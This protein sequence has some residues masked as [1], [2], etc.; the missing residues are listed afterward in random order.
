MSILNHLGGLALKG[1]AEGAAHLTGV[2]AIAASTEVI[3]GL[4]Q[5]Q[6]SDNSQRLPRAIERAATRAWRAVEVSLAGRS[7]WDRCKLA[8][9]TGDDRAIRKQVGA[10]LDANPLDGVDGHGPDFRAQCLAQLRAA[11]KAGLLDRG[12]IDPD[13]V[14]R[15]VGDLSRFGDKSATIDAEYGVLV[16]I[17][18]GLRRAGYEALATFLTLHPA[19]GPPLLVAAMRY[20]F[21]REVEADPRLFQGLSYARLESLGAGQQAGFG[22]LAEALDAGAERLESLLSDVQAVVVQTHGDVLDI[23][24]EL[25]RQGQQMN[26]LG[27]AVLQALAQQHLEKREL[28]GGDSFSIRNEDER[29]LV[30]D[31]VRRYRGL[32]RRSA[33]GCRR[34]STRWASSR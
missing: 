21:Q 16:S 26:E 15:Q 2:G 19:G 6:F 10:Y 33:G 14:A 4:L 30:R 1:A 27:Q 25:S 7:W 28:H 20:F 12:K 3:A 18:D 29:R 13:A 24:A 23:K 9:A 11:R 31:L 8:L 17:G 5:K 32:P 34:C 22:D